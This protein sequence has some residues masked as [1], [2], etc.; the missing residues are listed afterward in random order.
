[1]A[2][3]YLRTDELLTKKVS[4][5]KV[6]HGVVHIIEGD[7]VPDGEKIGEIVY[8]LEVPSWELRN[9]LKSRAVSTNMIGVS[10]LNGYVMNTMIVQY[11]LKSWSIDFKL[12]TGDNGDGYKV[13]TNF[14]ELMA[15]K[16][17]SYVFDAVVM[18]YNR[19]LA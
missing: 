12:E 2:A 16:I 8:T 10:G 15:A 3:F 14:K 19:Y 7:I 6:E 13:I 1:M 18:L 4:F 5:I 9:Y 11:L 17:E